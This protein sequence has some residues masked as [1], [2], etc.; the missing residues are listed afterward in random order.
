MMKK[1]ND[2]KFIPMTSVNSNSGQEVTKDV[3][4]Y[5]NQIVNIVMIGEV[6]KEGWVLV[7]TGMPKCADEMIAVARSR[8]D[9]HPPAAIVLTHGHFDHV[10]NVV[11]LLTHWPDVPVFAHPLEFPYLTGLQDYPE[12]DTS[13]E[14]GML[15]KLAA[16]Y[17][18]ESIDIKERLFPL[19]EDGQVPFL[20][21]WQW[22]HVPGHA[23]GQIALFREG[24]R[25]LLSADAIVTV[26]QDALY[27]VLMQK[28]EING[29]PRY[30]TTNWKAAYDSAVKL[31]QLRPALLIAG[32]GEAME[33]KDL[34][35]GLSRLIT[36]FDKI[37]IPKHGRFVD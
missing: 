30:L 10:G 32:H 7:D 3:F 5:T 33:G 11:D 23:P 29:P 14:G 27:K 1:S 4:Y 26:R 20:S 36:E 2:G 19:P 28:K 17:P 35:M 16:I 18:H 21:D 24:D 8:F 6:G 13:V 34:T 12:P 15:A 31:Q 9:E 22:I 25:L 37:A